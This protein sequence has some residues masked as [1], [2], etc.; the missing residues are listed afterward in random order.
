MSS[1]TSRLGQNTLTSRYNNLEG[2]ETSGHGT[3]GQAQASHFTNPPTYLSHRGHKRGIFLYSQILYV[4][5][6]FCHH[7]NVKN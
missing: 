6:F 4:R 7:Y 2:T 1:H 3:G 5:L